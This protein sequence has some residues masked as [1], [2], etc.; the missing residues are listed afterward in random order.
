[1]L[2]TGNWIRKLVSFYLG[3]EIKGVRVILNEL[4]SYLLIKR[5]W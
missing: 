5:G 4:P 3:S 2:A 1:M